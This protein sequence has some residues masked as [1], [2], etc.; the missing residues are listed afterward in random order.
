M[1]RASTGRNWLTARRRPVVL[2]LVGVL[3]V[4]L[5][6]LVVVVVVV[7]PPHLIDTSGMTAEARLKSENDLRATLVQPVGGVVILIGAV[8]AALTLRLNRKTSEETLELSTQGSDHRAFH[9]S[10]RP[11]WRLRKARRAPRWHLRSGADRSRL[12]GRPS[13]DH[14]GADRIPS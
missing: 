1:D 10:H 3:V 13:G 11:T 8:V 4:D 14:G 7:L 2:W 12:R 6:V 9:A 5:L